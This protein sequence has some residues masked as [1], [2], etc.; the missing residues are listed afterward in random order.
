[1]RRKTEH[2]SS[3]ELQKLP[4]GNND[5]IQYGKFQIGS[6][7]ISEESNVKDGCIQQQEREIFKH[8][9]QKKNSFRE[10]KF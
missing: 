8:L 3:D 10:Q 5:E 7:K 6:F 1:L 4:H 2:N 9:R